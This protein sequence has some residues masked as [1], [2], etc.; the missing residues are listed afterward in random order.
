MDVVLASCSK[1]RAT[2]LVPTQGVPA[3]T[4]DVPAAPP[5]APFRRPWRQEMDPVHRGGRV[6]TRDEMAVAAPVRPP[7]G[8]GATEAV[9]VQRVGPVLRRGGG[10]RPRVLAVRA[11]P[12]ADA[13]LP[14]G[15]P[16][17]VVR[18]R[19]RVA[20]AHPG[21]HGGVRDVHA[22]GGGPVREP[23]GRRRPE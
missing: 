6:S 1:S 4:Q 5:V 13:R 16:G 23:H 21:G 17:A 11:V 2:T 15:I 8:G 19:P 3:G 12:R 22:A 10:A 18:H 7:R 14:W 20:C 9:P